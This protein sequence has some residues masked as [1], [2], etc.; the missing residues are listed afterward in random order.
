MRK[1]LHSSPQLVF[2]EQSRAAVALTHRQIQSLQKKAEQSG[3]DFETILEVYRRGLREGGEKTAFGRVNSFISEGRA[4]DMDKDLIEKKIGLWDRIN[5]KRNRIKHGS[6]EHMRRPGEKGRPSSADLKNSQVKE[7]IMKPEDM[8]DQPVGNQSAKKSDE[9]GEIIGRM[10]V[11]RALDDFKSGMPDV[12]KQIKKQKNESYTN[13]YSQVNEADMP[14]KKPVSVASAND[15]SNKIQNS[16]YSYIPG[17]KDATT[18]DKLKGYAKAVGVPVQGDTIGGDKQYSA[19]DLSGKIKNTFNVDVH[20]DT[21]RDK[22]KEFNV[23]MGES[24]EQLG[25]VHHPIL[26]KVLGSNGK[27]RTFGADEADAHA[28]KHNGSIF[29][30][31]MGSVT[32]KPAYFVKLRER[33][34]LVGESYTGSEPT[35]KNMNDPASRFVGTT[36]LTDTYRNNTPGQSRTSKTIKKVIKELNVRDADGRVERVKKVDIRMA[37]GK[38]RKMNPGK[39]GSSGGGGE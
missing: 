37:N 21:I 27:P 38:I 4:Y 9:V 12:I 36:A 25:V 31:P 2:V 24:E 26:G 13:G 29:K 6:G 16:M 15:I 14:A 28:E 10:K 22:A 17:V 34:S 11:N 5:A 3:H 19:K 7:T 32:G 20:P 1:S 33:P 23:A 35:S 18:P 39:S 30:S 8:E